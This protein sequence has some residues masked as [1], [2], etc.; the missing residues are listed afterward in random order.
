MHQSGSKAGSKEPATNFSPDDPSN[1]AEHAA[2]AEE[3][4]T[5]GKG[6]LTEVRALIDE[7]RN[8]ARDHIRLAALET[9]QAGESI[10]RM[11]ISGVVAG[12][13]AFIGWASLISALVAFVVE[14]G[15]MSVSLTLLLCGL[16][17]IVMVIV[18]AFVIRK[19]GRA[20]L[21]SAVVREMDPRLTGE[22]GDVQKPSTMDKP[23]RSTQ[24]PTST[25]PPRS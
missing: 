17:H 16:I 21:L 25:P 9:R 20:L 6:L 24:R 23:N 13:V 10:V 1:A 7:Y 14:S 2:H 3:A 11:V 12:G 4:L 22:V 18:L 19:Q 8:L 5:L 15:W